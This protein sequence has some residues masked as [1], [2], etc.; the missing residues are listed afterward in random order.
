MKICNFKDIQDKKKSSL[1]ET[2]YL[3]NIV[4]TKT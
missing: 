3:N 1:F 2:K 4:I